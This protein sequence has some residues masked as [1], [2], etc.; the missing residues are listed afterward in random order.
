MPG[1]SEIGLVSGEVFF[2]RAMGEHLHIAKAG[3][4][5]PEPRNVAETI[6]TATP[7]Q[8]HIGAMAK[9]ASQRPSNTLLEWRLFR[10]L[11]QEELAE[12]VGTNGSVISLLEGGGRGL[13]DK[14][15]HKL[16]PA[17]GIRPGWL[18]DVR[19]EEVPNDLL[20]TWG[21]IDAR[22]RQQALRVLRSFR[23]TGTDDA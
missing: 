14:W 18:L 10:G 16:A 20:D 9:K 7:G 6:R 21:Q 3:C 19:P 5:A 12:R 13:S 15:A 2:D 4:Q 8:A 1:T 11:T 17:L 23:K 22:D